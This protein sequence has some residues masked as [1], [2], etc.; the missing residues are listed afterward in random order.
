LRCAPREL[1][2][3]EAEEAAR[4]RAEGVR[5]AYVA[6]TRARDLLVIPAV[7]DEPYPD[8][9]WLSPFAKAIY[10]ARSDWRKAKPAAE[11]PDFGVSSIVERP[12]EYVQQEEFSVRPGLI[13][14]STGEHEVVWWDPNILG[15]NAEGGF[16]LR[17]KQILVDDG[18]ENTK[19]Y[20]DWKSTREALIA[21]ASAPRY[22]VFIASQADAP[23]DESVPVEIV[24]V[25]KGKRPAM[26]K[27]FG[28]LVH[29][30]L[31]DVALDA[32]DAAIRAVVEWNA[33][34]V[35][36]SKEEIALSVDAI[37]A[38]LSTPIIARA[39]A[40]ERCHREYPFVLALDD[41]RLIEGILDLAFVENG[42]W[43]IVDFKTDVYAA[44][45]REQYER[46]LQWYG[47]AMRRLTKMPARA[48][49]LE[50]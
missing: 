10:P 4:E 6:A 47:F 5:V 33:R 46:Q 39:R 30:I 11:C 41:G 12:L 16:G 27:R 28:T 18:G 2:D 36:A 23:P 7:G 8:G 49:L 25:E 17:Q 26:G 43:I 14:P 13:R 32:N 22:D 15:L 40:A 48:V 50:I 9:G 42:E 24:A 35:G 44:G 20:R 45:R 21:K 3:H 29:N 38:T 37:K 34:S 31:R 1:L 19:S